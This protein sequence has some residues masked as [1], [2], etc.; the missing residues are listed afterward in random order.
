MFEG[1]VLCLDGAGETAAILSWSAHIWLCMS[2]AVKPNLARKFNVSE[3][4]NEAR[5]V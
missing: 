5:Y 1:S 2:S 3:P 4:G